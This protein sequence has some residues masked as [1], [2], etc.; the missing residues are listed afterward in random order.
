SASDPGEARLPTPPEPAFDDPFALLAP[1][2][3]SPPSA[4][5]EL[6]PPLHAVASESPADSPTAG[7]PSLD[8][9]PDFSTAPEP[10]L[11]TALDFP[12]APPPSLDSAPG[13]IQDF[14]GGADP[15]HS[16]FEMPP[17]PP[18]SKAKAPAGGDLLPEIP[19]A[20]PPTPGPSPAPRFAFRP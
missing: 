1:A 12:A 4:S 13:D 15:D 19:T 6:P 2:R 16:F 14:D 9:A 10:R 20:A 8:D 3:G 18:P 17:E 5:P 11:D 7:E